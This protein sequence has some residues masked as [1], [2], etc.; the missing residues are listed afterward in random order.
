MKTRSDNDTSRT[1][2]WNIA[3]EKGRKNWLRLLVNTGTLVGAAIAVPIV[4]AMPGP[5]AIT[6]GLVLTYYGCQKLT[7][8]YSGMR[9]PLDSNRAS[10]RHYIRD[11]IFEGLFYPGGHYQR[12]I[13]KKSEYRDPN[14]VALKVA[15][16]GVLTVGYLAFVAPVQLAWHYGP[17]LLS[18]PARLRPQPRK[19]APVDADTLS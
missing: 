13:A 14:K 4:L 10:N 17:K 3:V 6:G 2:P 5:N 18:L 16:L 9:K 11:I 19:P 7:D 1:S 8:V 15:G 12:N